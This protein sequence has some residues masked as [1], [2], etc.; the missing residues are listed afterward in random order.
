MPYPS[1]PF[2]N[3]MTRQLT[4]LSRLCSLSHFD[5]KFASVTEIVAGHTKAAGGNLFD[6]R[7]FPISV[8]FAEKADFVLTAFTAIALASNPVHGNGQCTVCFV[9]NRAK[10]HGTGSKAFEDIF[11]RLYLMEWNGFS[12]AEF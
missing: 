3:F 10:G 4:A 7:I 2:I 9:R 8:F 11:F 1:N 12:F 6:R 5:L